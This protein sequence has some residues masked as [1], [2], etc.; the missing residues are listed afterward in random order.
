MSKPLISV[1]VPAY[2]TTETLTATVESIE[3]QT[4]TDYELILI[5]DYSTD[6]TAAAIKTLATRYPNILPIYN[7]K[8]LGVSAVRNLGISY[9][10]GQF[11]AFVDAD[12]LIAPNYLE[13][14]YALATEHDADVAA[15]GYRDVYKHKAIRPPAHAQ[16]VKLFTPAEALA[17]FLHY[18][19]L[20]T[21]VWGKIIA[22]KLF[23]DL[24]FPEG[25]I[26]EDTAVMHQI[27]TR[28]NRVVF[29]P[30]VMYDYVQRSSS[31]VHTH[32]KARDVDFLLSLPDTIAAAHP[33]ADPQDLLYFKFK[34][35]LAVFNLML[36]TRS[37]NKPDTARILKF[38]RTNHPLIN[39]L[40]LSTKER[41]Q[42]A[43]LTLGV[44]PYQFLRSAQRLFSGKTTR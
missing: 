40:R 38:I 21:F 23:A 26:F 13:R 41:V 7:V 31:Q 27:Y 33:D 5:D 2:N 28:A 9:A 18:G 12:D 20:P 35:Y 42:F 29:T 16:R 44:G 17:S 34:T 3:R 14:L 24:K 1:I 32:R 22:K 10:Q 36:A 25:V 19:D 15:C 43:A 8:N 4:F 6:D 39:R 37:P 11:I 30:V